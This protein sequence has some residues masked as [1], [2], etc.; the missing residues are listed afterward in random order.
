MRHGQADGRTVEG[1]GQLFNLRDVVLI[2]VQDVG[3]H[4]V[5]VDHQSLLLEP[6]YRFPDGGAAHAQLILKL[7]DIQLAAQ[8][9]PQ[10]DDIAAQ[11]FIHLIHQGALFDRRHGFVS[12]HFISCKIL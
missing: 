12:F 8:G 10:R 2:Q 11:H 6:V 7:I 1:H 5:L 3:A 4:V 9:A